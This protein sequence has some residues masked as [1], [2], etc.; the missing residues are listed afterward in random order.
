MTAALF[1][2]CSKIPIKDSEWIGSKA[3]QGAVSFHT[4]TTE[5]HVFTFEQFLAL[6]NNLKHE[7]GPLICTHSNT[8]AELKKLWE[9]CVTNGGCEF[10][11]PAEK[12]QVNKFFSN[13][14]RVR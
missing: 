2:S 12:K 14:E 3:Q 5:K 13:V 6:W 1:L 4:L 8:F 10:V 9:E 11:T 7:D